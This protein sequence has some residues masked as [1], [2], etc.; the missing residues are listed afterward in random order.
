MKQPRAVKSPARWGC[1][2]GAAQSWD[3]RGPGA[4]PT[5]TEGSRLALPNR[6]TWRPLPE[7]G[8]TWRC[9]SGSR[10]HSVAPTASPPR[11]H[12]RSEALRPHH[13][14]GCMLP[15]SARAPGSP[16]V[17][18]RC[19]SVSFSPVVL[20]PH[21]HPVCS[22]LADSLRALTA[23]LARLLFVPCSSLTPRPLAVPPGSFLAASSAV[24]APVAGRGRG[25]G[26]RGGGIKQPSPRLSP[27]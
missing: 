4:S 25:R 3:A 22:S 5:D 18:P 27:C 16:A 6:C 7:G 14:L 15:F 24:L 8:G 2:H 1:V 13:T 17:R 19:G 21:L 26:G 10:P 20:K 23:V 12:P 9:P 11:H